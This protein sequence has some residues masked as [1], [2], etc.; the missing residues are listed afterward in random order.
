M[1]KHLP[2]SELNSTNFI[3]EFKCEYKDVV[4]LQD[5]NPTLFRRIRQAI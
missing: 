3:K 1:S 2:N 5:L 4:K